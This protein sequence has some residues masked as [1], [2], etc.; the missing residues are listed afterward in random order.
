[1]ISENVKFRHIT[2]YRIQAEGIYLGFVQTKKE[3]VTLNGVFTLK[4]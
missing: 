3:H 1:M 4:F 2:C